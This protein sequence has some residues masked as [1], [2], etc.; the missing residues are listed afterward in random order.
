[1]LR[2]LLSGLAGVAA[3]TVHE[4]PSG[5]GPASRLERAERLLFVRD[6]FSWRAALFSPFYLL[7]RGEWL[8]LAL[9]A[10]AAL[11]L[12]ALLS[13]IGA[14]AD[15]IAWSFVL[16]NVVVGFEAS[17]I[18]RWS[19][20]RAGWQEVGSVSGRG[21][22]EAERRFFEAW[23]PTL[24]EAAPPHAGDNAGRIAV[25]ETA[26]IETRM[27]AAVRRLAARLRERFA[28]KP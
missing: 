14:K 11:A 28:V 19:L 2:Y 13:L 21:R 3:F 9:Y 18:K 12:V 1:M 8:A 24:A 20:G 6:G 25:P 15:W 23:M 16:L 4:P 22:D 27:E 17:E 10:I 26:D 5:G 7:I